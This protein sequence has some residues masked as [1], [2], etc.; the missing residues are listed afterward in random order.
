MNQPRENKTY[1]D[2][3]PGLP[4]KRPKPPNDPDD[5]TD[6]EVRPRERPT[7]PRSELAHPAPT[8]VHQLPTPPAPHTASQTTATTATPFLTPNTATYTHQISCDV[9]T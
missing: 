1:T 3:P 8:G 9:A 2:T 5:T 7:P 6:E 4:K